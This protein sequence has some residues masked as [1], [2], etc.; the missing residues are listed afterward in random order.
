MRCRR[1]ALPQPH[2]LLDIK[3][4]HEIRSQDQRLTPELLGALALVVDHLG[5]AYLLRPIQRWI[6][7]PQ[8]RRDPASFATRC[9]YP[10]GTTRSSADHEAAVTRVPQRRRRARTSNVRVLI[11]RHRRTAV[12]T[13]PT[14]EARR[15]RQEWCPLG[16]RAETGDDDRSERATAKRPQTRNTILRR[17]LALLQ[18]GL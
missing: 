11:A 18:H 3:T 8:S 17:P 16:A 14:G 15:S 13:E 7:T 9:G 12:D 4:W 2:Q 6:A 10:G 1:D 5:D